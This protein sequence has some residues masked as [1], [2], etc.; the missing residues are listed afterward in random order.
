V[1]PPVHPLGVDLVGNVNMPPSRSRTFH[2]HASIVHYYYSASDSALR[3][4]DK[5]IVYYAQ[6]K[7]TRVMYTRTRNAYAAVIVRDESSHEPETIYFMRFANA[8][9]SPFRFYIIV[10]T[11]ALEMG[12]IVL[13]GEL[14]SDSV[15]SSF[16]SRNISYYVVFVVRSPH[17]RVYN[18]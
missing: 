7:H 14:F 10:C 12:L 13:L 5:R 16:R 17:I 8:R 3:T 4:D 6:R 2:P 18:I 11:R 9:Q 15:V 1:P